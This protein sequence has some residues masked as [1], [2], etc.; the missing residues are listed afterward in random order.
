M[1]ITIF[2]K[3]VGRNALGLIP[4]FLSEADPRPAKEQFHENY[5]HGG[6]WRPFKGFKLDILS[7][8]IKYPGD[9]AY[10]PL[11]KIILRKEAIYIYPNAWV[12]IIQPNGDHEISRMD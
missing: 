2:N 1:N 9:P 6:G 11:A 12:L 10:L 7:M 8:S 4:A 5:A 3:K